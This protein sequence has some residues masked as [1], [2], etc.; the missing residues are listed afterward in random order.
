MLTF[1]PSVRIYLAAGVTDMRKSFDGLA[2][3]TENLL[4]LDPLSGHVFVFCNR[5]KDRL[6]L[7]FWDRAG[8]WCLAKRLEQGTFAW[9][10]SDPVTRLEMTTRELLLILEGID[11]RDVRFRK[12]MNRRPA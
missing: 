7:L 8:Y 12:R 4:E 10:D 9:P 6:K 2:S 5:R 3:V 1:P 11:H